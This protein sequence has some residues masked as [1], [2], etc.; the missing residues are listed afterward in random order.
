MTLAEHFVDIGYQR[1]IKE[2]HAEGREEARKEM[3]HQ[4]IQSGLDKQVIAKATGIMV[5]ELETL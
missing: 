2:G 3:I 5:E 1:G 4:L